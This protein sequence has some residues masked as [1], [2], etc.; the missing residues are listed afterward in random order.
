MRNTANFPF[1][2]GPVNVYRA[3]SLVGKS[4][5][6]SVAEGEKMELFLGL[7]ER[8]KVTRKADKKRSSSTRFGDRK[9]LNVGY[10]IQISN[11]LDSAATVIV[12]DQVPVPREDSVKVKVIDVT[13]KT[14][15]PERGIIT[16]QVELAPKTTRDLKF[17]FQVDYPANANLGNASELE[18]QVDYAF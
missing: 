9:R 15:K 8:I 3:G 7:E 1:L 17:E 18:R 6:D 4:K 2:P 13:P 5:L 10:T 16:W 12:S 11:Y 14:A